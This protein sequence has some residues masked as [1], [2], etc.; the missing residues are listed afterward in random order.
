MNLKIIKNTTPDKMHEP[1]VSNNSFCLRAYHIKGIHAITAIKNLI[2][3]S[4]I[5]W[6]VKIMST[7]LMIKDYN[8]L[9]VGMQGVNA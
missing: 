9:G 5:C 1:K 8:K 2:K 3:N 7:S 6:I 4:V